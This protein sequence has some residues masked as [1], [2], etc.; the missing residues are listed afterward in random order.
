MIVPSVFELLDR[1]I[2]VGEP[3]PRKGYTTQKP[4]KPRGPVT[5]P[6]A[7]VGKLNEDERSCVLRCHDT[8]D[9]D[10]NDEGKNVNNS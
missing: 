6:A 4:N 2:L 7:V 3:Y 10:D 1:V 9:D 8:K 5:C